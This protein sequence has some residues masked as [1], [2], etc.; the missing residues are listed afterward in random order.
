MT[1]TGRIAILVAAVTLFVARP[2]LAHHPG[3]FHV[4][5]ALVIPQVINVQAGSLVEGIGNLFGAALTNEV[6]ALGCCGA[7]G[8]A[9][10]F[11][12]GAR[13]ANDL[14]LDTL[15]STLTSAIVNFPTP[16]PA[17][18]FTFEFDPSLGTFVRSTDSFG[19]IYADRAETI[20]KG[21][22]SFGFTYSRLTFDEV[23]G[24]DLENGELRFVFLHEPTA[25]L[26]RQNPGRGAVQA[27]PFRFETD[28][29]TTQLFLDL[30]ADLFVLSATY[31]ILDRLDV[32][33]A[34]PIIRIDVDARA[35]S[36]SN[37]ESQT[38]NA[39]AAGG[40]LAHIFPNGT[41]TQE[42]RFSDDSTGIGDLLLRAKY[43]F[44]R[45]KAVALAGLLELRLPT[46]DEDDFRGLDTVR[47][48]PFFVASGNFKGIAPHVNLGFDLGDTSKAKDEFLYRVGFDWGFLRWATFA[49]DILG[50]WVIDNDRVELGS[51][52]ATC[53]GGTGPA[54]TGGTRDVSRPDA[55][56][57]IID[58]AVGFKF[59]PWRNVLI[60][61]N[62]LIPLN[63]T[64]LRDDFTP[65]VGVEVTF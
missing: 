59:N 40:G 7:R 4:D 31:G 18:G 37:N 21:K 9:D 26:N 46:G 15:R 54:C 11:S 60:L 29:I 20:G 57:H 56:D 13:A 28:T 47:V 52:Q 65:L 42:S 24:R 43:N 61:V 53:R 8:H 1:Q 48:R 27:A 12:A 34:L 6:R 63:D 16:S 55:D 22:F 17:A 39:P 19:P 33:V 38:L 64:G 5:P 14:L 3:G 41:A 49:F 45:Q 10:H 36:T 58:A 62:V 2:G 32:S 23:D 25:E 30:D 51:D 35:V 44:Y 50:R